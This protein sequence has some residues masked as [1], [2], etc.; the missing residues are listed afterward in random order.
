MRP[1]HI[2]CLTIGSRGDVQPYVA[3]C[4][5]LMKDGHQCT[6]VSHPE[7]K[8]WVISHGVSYRAAGGDPGLLMKL[9]VDNKMFSVQFFK[10]TLGKFRDWLDELLREIIEQCSDADLIIESPST[11]G[12]IHVAEALGIGYMRA[13]TM[14]WTKTASYPQAFSVPKKD[15]GPLY[16]SA[17]YAMY[18]QV[19]WLAS[20]GHINRWRTLMLGLAP[21]ELSRLNTGSVPFMVSNLALSQ[22]EKKRLEIPF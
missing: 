22:V 19:I 7:Y 20:A 13:F 9:S 21:T 16:N 6:I 3:L 11:F 8:N 12:G 18:D 4:K 17:S 2:V 10:E 15:M 14:P 5:S 1:I